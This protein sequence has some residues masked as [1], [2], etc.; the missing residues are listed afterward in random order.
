M[1]LA[2]A[3]APNSVDV[4]LQLSEDDNRRGE[5]DKAITAFHKVTEL[6]P[7]NPQHFT[8]IALRYEENNRKDYTVTK[9]QKL[10]YIKRGMVAGD[11]AIEIR[12]DYFEALTYKNLLLRQQALIEPARSEELI[13]E[14][15]RS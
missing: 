2:E 13:A 9:P 4:I 10:E 14:A 6:E 12:P 8:N 11:R 7:T 15:A 3:A 1:K 5:F